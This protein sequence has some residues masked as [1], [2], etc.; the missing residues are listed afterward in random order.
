M[1]VYR[2]QGLNHQ[3]IQNEGIETG[4]RRS[5]ADKRS[6]YGWAK[7]FSSDLCDGLRRVD[8]SDP[9]L[10]SDI[11]GWPDDKK[12]RNGLQAQLARKSTSVLLPDPLELTSL[13]E[14]A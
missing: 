1:S 4:K 3:Q 5:D 9:S 7:F 6:L 10:H 2:I 11:V 8:D 12:K 14:T 13:C